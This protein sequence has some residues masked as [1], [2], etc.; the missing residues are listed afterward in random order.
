MGVPSTFSWVLLL[1]TVPNVCNYTFRKP[2]GIIA[3]YEGPETVCVWT[4]QISSGGKIVLKLPTIRLNCAK[5]KLEIMNGP[6]GSSF[7]GKPCNGVNFLYRSTSN[8]M[9]IRYS[10]KSGFFPSFFSMSYSKI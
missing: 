10:R 4:I 5:E 1:C 9:T 8:V 3:N 2:S 6:V 7:L